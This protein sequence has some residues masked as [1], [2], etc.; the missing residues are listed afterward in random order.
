MSEMK[1]YDPLS[2][3]FYHLGRM[4][5]N[6]ETLKLWWSGSGLVMRAKCGR[7]DVEAESTAR[8][9]AQFLGV[10]IDGAPVCRLP[11]APG[12]HVYPVLAGMLNEAYH[13]I[14]ILRDTQPSY[15]E[16]GP[17][18]LHAVYTDGE[19]EAP[20]PKDTVIEFIGDSLTVGEG[21]VGPKSGMEWILPY[22]SH[23]PAFPTLASV[24][25]DAEKRVVALGG[26]GAYK[27]WDGKHECRIGAIYERLCAVTPG[28]D[29]PYSFHERPADY[30]VINLGT[31]DGTALK[32][33]PAEEKKKEEAL[34]TRDAE[35][36]LALVRA[37]QPKACILWAYGLCGSVMEKGIRKAVEQRQSAGDGR[38]AYLP[39]PEAKDVGSRMHPSREAHLE[40]ART[41]ADA[42]RAWKGENEA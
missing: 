27:S 10:M 35:A 4:E 34:F 38:V 23:M 18:I 15:D 17:V 25:L 19:M 3:V 5:E 2:S 21:T 42:I 12:K 9:H 37:H 29:T 20:A 24:M 7:I 8:N 30:V 26:W 6:A 13:E 1:R 36:L 41:I 28:G 39:L 31:N 40:A 14:T 16:D 22:I 32:D 33:L 11:L